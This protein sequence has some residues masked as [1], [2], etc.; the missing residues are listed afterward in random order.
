MT[1]EMVPAVSVCAPV[2]KASCDA[3][4]GTVTE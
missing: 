1:P 2:V 3:T 4:A